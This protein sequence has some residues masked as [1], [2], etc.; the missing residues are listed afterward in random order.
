[1]KIKAVGLTWC[2]RENWH[3]F[4]AM[5]ADGEKMPRSYD[6]WLS[7]AEQQRKNLEQQ[8]LTV[9]PAPLEPATFLERCHRN[10]IDT[11]DAA[12][13]NRFAIEAAEQFL[14]VQH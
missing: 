5:M 7:F 11:P 3:D 6:Q 2:E 9:V 8:G 12:A 13:C 1:M 10:G 14:L 4:R